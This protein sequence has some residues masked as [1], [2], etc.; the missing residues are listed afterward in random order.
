MAGG[1][2]DGVCVAGGGGGVTR[3][4]GIPCGCGTLGGAAGCGERAGAF[5]GSPAGGFELVVAGA[6]GVGFVAGA[7]G[8]KI[9]CAFAGRRRTAVAQS[10]GA[11]CRSAGTPSIQIRHIPGG[12]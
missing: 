3:V 4:G 9:T 7:C 11:G 12:G 10:V 5:C 1:R 6:V 8:P 2:T